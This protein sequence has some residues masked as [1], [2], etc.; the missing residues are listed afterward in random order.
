[1]IHI[2][3]NQSN[4]VVLTLSEL[5]LNTMPKFWML[6]LNPEQSL[7]QDNQKKLKLSDISPTSAYNQFEIKEPIDIELKA[8]FYEYKAYQMP[9]STTT[10]ESLG[11]LVEVGL[12]RVDGESVTKKVHKTENKVKVYGRD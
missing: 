8:G 12:M 4:T 5:A 7:K 10:D 6:I 9:D 3:K 2:K 1:M 11:H